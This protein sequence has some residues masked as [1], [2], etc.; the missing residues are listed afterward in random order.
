MNEVHVVPSDARLLLSPFK[1]VV[2]GWLRPAIA[3]VGPVLHLLRKVHVCRCGFAACPNSWADTAG[4]VQTR[5]V[6]TAPVLG[7]GDI[8]GAVG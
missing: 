3:L 1:A 2:F 5:D 6:L 4:A 7:H 8:S